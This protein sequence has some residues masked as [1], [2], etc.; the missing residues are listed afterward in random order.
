MYKF[1]E[2]TEDT[3]C[4]G[5]ARIGSEDQQ[6]AACSLKQMAG[7]DLGEP[8]HSL[9]IAGPHLHPLETEYLQQFKI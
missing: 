1:S 4:I 3:L 8:L 2:V 6:I 5:L 9:I 7:L